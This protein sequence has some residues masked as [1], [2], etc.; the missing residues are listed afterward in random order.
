MAPAPKTSAN[1]KLNLASWNVRTSI[2]HQGRQLQLLA[3]D[4]QKNNISICA[5]QETRRQDS[6]SLEVDDYLFL[7][8]ASDNNGNY[9]VGFAISKS[10]SHNITNWEPIN[11][12]VCKLHI[13]INGQSVILVSALAPT[14]I[15]EADLKVAFYSTL[16]T[17]LPRSTVPVFILGDFNS[18]V[19]NDIGSE[20]QQFLSEFCRSNSLRI[21]NKSFAHKKH[22][23]TTFRQLRSTVWVTLDL[24]LLSKAAFKM[25]R[26]C[27]NIFQH[28]M[29]SDHRPIKLTITTQLKQ[30]KRRRRPAQ[31]DL[32]SLSNHTTRDHY[33]KRLLQQLNPKCSFRTN[34]NRI[35]K[36][37]KEHCVPRQRQKDWFTVHEDTLLPLIKAKATAFHRYWSSRSVENYNIY[38]TAKKLA[39]NAI[40]SAKNT[41]LQQIAVDIEKGA[42]ENDLRTVFQ[43]IP[44]LRDRGYRKTILLKTTEKFGVTDAKCAEIFRDH[45]ST[46]LNCAPP[47]RPP[48]SIT[49]MYPTPTRREI[50]LLSSRPEDNEIKDSIRALKHNK[51]TGPDNLHAELW[52]Y[53]G[54]AAFALIR[55]QIRLAWERESVNSLWTESDVIP[56]FKKGDQSNPANYR[57]ISLL[58]T[59]GSI[60]TDLLNK[61]LKTFLETRLSE[62]QHGFRPHRST[63]DLIFSLRQMQEH[64][65]EWNRPLYAL[66]IDF[67]KAF[68]SI[69]REDLCR[70]LHGVGIP[71]NI[72][73]IVQSLHSRTTSKIRLGAERSSSFTTQTGVRQGCKLAPLLFALH[74][75]IVVKKLRSQISPDLFNIAP[76][77]AWNQSKTI[78]ESSQPLFEFMFAD[79]LTFISSSPEKLQEALIKL[80]EFSKAIGLRINS[81]KTFVMALNSRRPLLITL[82]L[83]NTP[84]EQVDE[85]NFLGSI[86]A[87][88]GSFDGEIK[89]RIRKAATKRGKLTNVW[90]SNTISTKTKLLIFKATVLPVLLYGAESW[91]L[92][93]R[94]QSRLRAFVTTALKRI[95][96]IKWDKHVTNTDLY[97]KS[98]LL[99]PEQLIKRA[100]LRYFGHL[101]RMESHRTPQICF[102]QRY[103]GPRPSHGTKKRWRDLLKD[104]LGD[105]P[106]A[107]DAAKDRPAWRSRTTTL[108]ALPIT[109]KQSNLPPRPPTEHTCT[110]TD[111]NKVCSS[112]IGL[113]SHMNAHKRQDAKSVTCPVEGCNFRT[114][115]TKRLYAHRLQ[116]HKTASGKMNTKD[117]ANKTILARAALISCPICSHISTKSGIGRHKCKNFTK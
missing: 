19:E 68:D 57:P 74:L 67:S 71:G 108:S 106:H 49:N 86:I 76:K 13:D 100:R 14:N 21:A 9:G 85:F 112:K 78:I 15:A 58:N 98:N 94:Q 89:M 52:Q 70:V 51:A 34:C 80:N 64:A 4:L 114:T 88:D 5:L 27:K 87:S 77:D 42:R 84:I 2:G 82:L 38:K 83:N 110:Y 117:S 29:I 18:D 33:Q 60:L 8:S 101:L 46:T 66:F 97:S 96:R 45:F 53:G 90:N 22:R 23:R 92:L 37:A 91:T 54:K 41:W 25:A 24:A 65:N 115:T 79:D 95:H 40:T 1:H 36:A 113:V 6:T 31:L 61:R 44:K 62:S 20:N 35:Y 111:C 69:D 11:E 10:T 50:L 32:R 59:S 116:M 28:L 72:V 73:N 63:Q 55:K 56:L 99:L 81:A 47:D 109:K 17:L 3:R 43:S 48:I 93:S 12:R 75:D 30:R 26:D 107:E 104:D 105:L 102:L 16:E 7:F 103:K 39:N